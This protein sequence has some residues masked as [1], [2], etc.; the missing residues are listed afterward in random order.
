[1][2]SPEVKEMTDRFIAV[3]NDDP[4]QV[5]TC[6]LSALLTIMCV[7][8]SKDPEKALKFA[9][10]LSEEFLRLFQNNGAGNAEEILKA[11][12]VITPETLQ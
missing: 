4:P 9:H 10:D 6:A 12:W 3:I 8:H 1:M 2:M 11:A 7:T 5:I